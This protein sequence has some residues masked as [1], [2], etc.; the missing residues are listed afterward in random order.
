M[1]IPPFSTTAVDVDVDADLD[2][3]VAASKCLNPISFAQARKCCIIPNRTKVLIM[4]LADK[5]RHIPCS[6]WLTEE[7]RWGGALCDETNMAECDI[8]ID[9]IKLVWLFK[10]LGL[11]YFLPQIAM[12]IWAFI[13]FFNIQGTDCIAFFII[14]AWKGAL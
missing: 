8:K 11:I 12:Y 1:Q 5:M 13:F 9:K 6:H 2:V 7:A 10:L 4:W 14:F 3:D